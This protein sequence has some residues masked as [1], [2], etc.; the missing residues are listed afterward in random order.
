MTSGTTSVRTTK[1]DLS[2]E[3]LLWAE[4]G[5]A[6]RIQMQPDNKY[7]RRDLDIILFVNDAKV[8]RKRDGRSHPRI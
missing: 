3:N 1:S 5:K 7:F 6:A 4:S 2:E 8:Q